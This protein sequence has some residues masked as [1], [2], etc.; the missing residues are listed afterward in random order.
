MNGVP[1]RNLRLVPRMPPVPER[2]CDQ[3]REGATWREPS[4]EGPIQKRFRNGRFERLMPGNA[5]WEYL[6]PDGEWVKIKQ[7]TK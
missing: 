1:P 2:T 4:P 3:M 5:S 6:D 7:V